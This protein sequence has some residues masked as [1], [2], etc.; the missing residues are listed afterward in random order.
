M[1]P[2]WR[3]NLFLLDHLSLWNLEAAIIVVLQLCMLMLTVW[4]MQQYTWAGSRSTPARTPGLGS[5]HGSDERGSSKRER[6]RDARKPSQVTPGEYGFNTAGP[7]EAKDWAEALQNV[8]SR[9]KKLEHKQRKQATDMSRIEQ[10][11]RQRGQQLG[12]VS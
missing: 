4:V 2:Q 3:L 11:Q 7:E 12:V 10:I 8:A 5:R 6:S 9:V 1:T